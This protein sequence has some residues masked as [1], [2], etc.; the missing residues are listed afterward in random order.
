[1][2]VFKKKRSKKSSECHFVEGKKVKMKGQFNY[3]L[4]WCKY[5][6]LFKHYIPDERS[7][8]QDFILSVAVAP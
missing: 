5:Y 4:K 2:K 3:F 7:K 8:I 6:S 1:M